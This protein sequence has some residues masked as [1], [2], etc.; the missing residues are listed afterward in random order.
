MG[1]SLDERLKK[2]C[3]ETISEE[4]KINIYEEFE[5]V[6]NE[7][8]LSLT[9]AGGE[10]RFN[11]A[12]P[13]VKSIIA[14]GTGSSIGLML[15]SLA[16]TKIWRL[17]GGEGQDMEID[18][19]KGISRLSALYKMMEQVN[20]Y[21]PDNPDLMMSALM[22]LFRTKDGKYMCPDCN[23]PKLRDRI[24]EL[25]GCNNNLTSVAKAI[26]QLD[27]TKLDEKANEKGGVMGKVR[28][29]K[30]FMEEPVYKD[31]LS[32]L[33]LIEIEMIGESDPEPFTMNPKTL[34]EGIKA[35]GMGHIIAGAG[36]GRALACHGAEVLNVWKPN[37]FE[38]NTTYLSADIGMRPCRI[39]YKKPK[40]NEQVKELLKDADIFFVNRRVKLMEEIGM[41]AEE[42]AKIR[43]GIIYCNTSFA[44]NGGLWRDRVGY[45]QVA[46]VVTGMTVFDGTE[47]E[48]ML[49]C[50]NVV[51]DFIVSWLAAAGVI[52]ALARRAKE[53]GSYRVHV[54]LCR[55]AL[56]LM[57]LGIFDKKFVE[58]V[59]GTS[60]LHEEKMPELFTAKTPLGEYQG[61]TDQ[62]KMSVLKEEYNPVLV[63]RGSSVPK[64]L[65][66]GKEPE[67]HTEDPLANI[68]LIPFN[69]IQ[70]MIYKTYRDMGIM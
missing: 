48:P 27:S 55:T 44:G 37:E 4:G 59:A 7:I 22:M 65:V 20:G 64:W 62:V 63:P 30:E 57:S 34:L 25:L 53:G 61:Y 33:P 14:L 46:G 6:A 35:L 56:W 54:S 19:A 67:W 26:L 40:G 47:N 41:T 52:E 24:Q 58:E 68:E 9:D 38:F 39:N 60:G 16:A 8:G 18:I 5:R 45:D 15:K 12:D 69:D 23:M 11:G 3:N 70:Q 28:S 21:C 29:L 49:P 51:N 13:I 50:I 42:C 1:M 17:R 36:L 43:P 32:K 31:Y 2:S 10:I 66:D